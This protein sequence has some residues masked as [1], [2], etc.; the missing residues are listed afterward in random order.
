MCGAI[1]GCPLSSLQFA[2]VPELMTISQNKANGGVVTL[3]SPAQDQYDSAVWSP[4]QSLPSHSGRTH[5][6][7]Q[8]S[9]PN[10]PYPTRP[11]S[12]QPTHNGPR[13]TASPACKFAQCS[14]HIMP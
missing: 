14:I 8:R 5:A 2:T 10:G 1:F 11:T 7:Q 3:K 6:T 13:P 12:H 4:L 9:P